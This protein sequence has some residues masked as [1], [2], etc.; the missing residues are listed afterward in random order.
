MCGI[1]TN[2]RGVHSCSP[3]AEAEPTS[4]LSNRATPR[5]A[6][7]PARAS[8]LPQVSSSAASEQKLMARLSS[9]PAKMNSSWMPAPEHHVLGE[10]GLVLIVGGATP[11][12]AQK[13]LT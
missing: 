11:R 3:A 10:L 6:P 2:V 4:S 12:A 1:A 7:S 8:A 9:R 5:T 13:V